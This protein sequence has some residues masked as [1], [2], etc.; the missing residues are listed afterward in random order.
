MARIL[1][2][3]RTFM[4]RMGTRSDSYIIFNFFYLLVSQRCTVMPYTVRSIP[5]TV[6]AWLCIC[7]TSLIVVHA[8]AT[9]RPLLHS[10]H[11]AGETSLSAS[12]L[13]VF[14]S[15]QP[16][17]LQSAYSE[18]R[19]P[20]RAAVT[21]APMF[22]LRSSHSTYFCAYTELDCRI[23]RCD[24]PAVRCVCFTVLVRRSSFFKINSFCPYHPIILQFA[25]CDVGARIAPHSE[26]VHS[27][28]CDRHFLPFSLCSSS[29]SSSYVFKTCA[30]TQLR[31][32]AVRHWLQTKPLA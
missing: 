20:R 22:R 19:S 14:C 29:A 8:A 30:F 15:S 31:Q 16:I 2:V 3:F 27:F 6:L 24:R 17:V 23:C 26:L 32:S 18:R 7:A 4:V 13:N 9:G 11:R 28:G 21:T 5:V 10:F 1:A 12:K 25:Y